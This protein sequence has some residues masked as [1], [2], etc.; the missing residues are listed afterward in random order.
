[1]RFNNKEQLYLKPSKIDGAS[2]FLDKCIFYNFC[3]SYS[4]IKQAATFH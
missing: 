1:M 4:A 2:E 3:C